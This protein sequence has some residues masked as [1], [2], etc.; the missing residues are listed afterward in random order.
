MFLFRDLTLPIHKEIHFA[1]RKI[2]GLGFR[3]SFCIISRMG[4]SYP[5]YFNK[6]NSYNFSLITF[7]LKI[8]VISDVRI[9]KEI[10]FR[11]TRLKDLNCVRGL[12]H[13]M[14]LP[15]HGQRTRTNASTQRTKRKRMFRYR[16]NIK[17]KKLCEKIYANKKQK[18][19]SYLRKG[20]N[21]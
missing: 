21:F 2:F 10:Q 13:R 12:R 4:L 9:K 6:I 7:L 11:I 1:L 18:V 19:K 3:K 20:E 17:V 16:F 15:L 8:L 5:Y 14:S